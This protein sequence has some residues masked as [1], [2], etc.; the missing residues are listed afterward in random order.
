TP[1]PSSKA[2][3]P[4]AGTRRPPSPRRAPAIAPSART[5]A[6]APS[7]Y[8]AQIFVQGS[9]LSFR[10]S[11]SFNAILGSSSGGAFGGGVRLR[12]RR[13][14]FEASL[15]RFKKDGERAFVFED[16][17]YPLGI[18]NT[19]TVEPMSFIVGLH[20][21]RRDRY[22]AYAGL[23]FGKCGYKEVSDFEDAADSID[24]SYTSY[25]LLLGAEARLHPWVSVALEAQGVSVPDALGAGGVSAIFEEKDLGY[26]AVQLKVLIGR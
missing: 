22:N 8:G 4:V 5:T 6:T 7:P 13:I 19:V 2:S 9:Y 20:L 16:V 10:A 23:G 17:V 26:A 3:Q 25:G 1:T 14:F 18:S 15:S 24:E 12:Y 11:E 21:I